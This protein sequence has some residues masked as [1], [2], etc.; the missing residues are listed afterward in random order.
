MRWTRT[1]KNFF[2]AA[3]NIEEE[4]DE[5]IEELGEVESMLGTMEG[6]GDITAVSELKM[7]IA[8]TVQR[9]IFKLLFKY[10]VVHHSLFLFNLLIGHN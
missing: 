6:T 7:V 5:E 9:I 10:I 4:I 2:T 8:Y 3:T 1:F